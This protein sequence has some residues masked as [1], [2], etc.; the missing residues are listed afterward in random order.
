MAWLLAVR[1]EVG[2]AVP[3]K[4]ALDGGTANR[5]GHA[6]PVSNFEIKMGCA[7]LTTR[8]DIG[9]RAGSFFSDS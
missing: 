8:A 1:A 6:F 9:I 7:Q 4:N 2:A 5:T 3:Q